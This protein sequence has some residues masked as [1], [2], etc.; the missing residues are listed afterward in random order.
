MRSARPTIK[1]FT[2]KRRK[3][4]RII[5]RLGAVA[6]AAALVSGLT[7]SGASATPTGET[8]RSDAS[9]P[10]A[11]EVRGLLA[12]NAGSVQINSDTV[13]LSDG[14]TI[15]AFA[16]DAR[17]VPNSASTR[18]PGGHLCLFANSNWGGDQWT[19]SASSCAAVNLFDYFMGNGKSWADQASSIDNPLPRPSGQAEFFHN[20]RAIA[21]LSPGH[22]LRNLATDGYN[23]YIESL[24]P[25]GH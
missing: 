4:M 3:Q 6:A 22:Y 25:C 14:S 19:S 2:I 17:A 10:V 8:G 18:C 24:Y 9:V 11:T 12:H 1:S 13:R 16:V 21:F 5:S 20:N 15:T 7:M 23:D